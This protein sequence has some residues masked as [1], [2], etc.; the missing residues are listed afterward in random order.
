MMIEICL[1][2]CLTWAG[3]DVKLPE[4]R[5]LPPRALPHPLEAR[6]RAFSS[7][8]S[9]CS[10]CPCVVSTLATAPAC[11]RAIE[12]SSH[13]SLQKRCN[14]CRSPRLW[15]ESLSPEQKAQEYI[16]HQQA[17]VGEKRSFYKVTVEEVG[18]DDR[19]QDEADLDFFL[20]AGEW[21]AKRLSEHPKLD[22]ITLIKEFKDLIDNPDAAGMRG[23][24]GWR[25]GL[26]GSRSSRVG[27]RATG[28]T[29]GGRRLAVI[30][31]PFRRLGRVARS[32]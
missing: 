24:F 10:K 21:K 5:S 23:G 12:T 22:G 18:Y 1:Y 25:R 3:H 20:L 9:A 26:V 17:K 32:S 30:R 27:G 7:A 19:Y 15:W 11:S 16:K 8:R 6:P 31:R 14:T 4:A 29:S 28:R 2:Q 13:N